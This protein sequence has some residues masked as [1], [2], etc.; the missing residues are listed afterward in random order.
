MKITLDTTILVRA[1]DDTGGLARELQPSI[2][3]GNHILVTSS[4][5]LAETSRVLR[6]SRM[7]NRH[8]MPESRIYDYV[9]HLKSV[10]LMAR[11]DPTLIAPIRDPNDIVVLQTA[12]AGGA[13]VLCSTDEDF[14]TPP[15]SGFLRSA[16]IRVFTDAELMRRLRS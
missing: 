5:I 3:E 8:K 15:A 7:Y 6:Y 1:F 11:P 14:F 9:M 16:D 10:A 4:G 2:L 12:I 13:E